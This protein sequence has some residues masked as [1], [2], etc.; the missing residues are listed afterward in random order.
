MVLYQ[1]CIREWAWLDGIHPRVL[2]ELEHVLYRGLGS[3]GG[4]PADWKPARII[5][6]YKEGMRED[7]GAYSP[8]SLSSVPRKNKMER[9]TL[10][11]IR[12]V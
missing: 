6:I 5:P 2:K 1:L 3:L 10:G 9:I 8:V 7:P 12:G 11:T 4:V